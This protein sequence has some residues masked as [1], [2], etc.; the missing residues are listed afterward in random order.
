MKR[1]PALIA[2]A[3]LVSGCRSPLDPEAVRNAELYFLPRYRYVETPK[4]CFTDEERE[5]ALQECGR[6]GGDTMFEFVVDTQGHVSK[7][8]LVQTYQP[9]HRH[10]DILAHAQ[11]MVFTPNTKNELY[12]AFYFPTKYTYNAEFEWLGR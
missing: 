2:S 3:L 10:E 6:L 1:I 12:R 9:A 4:Y 7:V 11:T 8:R 5:H